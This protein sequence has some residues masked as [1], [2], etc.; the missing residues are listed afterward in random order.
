[1]LATDRHDWNL[2]WTNSSGK[3]YFFERLA[4]HQ[5]INH[6]PNSS[7]LTRKDRLL[8]N[9]RKMQDKFSK[10]YFN[11]IPQSYIIPEEFDQFKRAFDLYRERNNGF[12]G[13]SEKQLINPFK[14]GLWIVKPSCSSRGR[15]IKIID[16]PSQVALNESQVVCRYID[17]PL[18][19]FGHK[20]D[21]RVYVLVTCFDPLRVYVFREGLVRFASEK[22]S[23]DQMNKDN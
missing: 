8:L 4:T 12:A 10:T 3:N 7:E 16:D 11:F 22:Y 21:L 20:F 14:K 18:L 1:M 9:F 5:R 17:N 15:G 23:T 2:L 13:N 19:L 6:F